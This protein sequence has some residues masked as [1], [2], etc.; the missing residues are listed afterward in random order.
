MVGVT[1]SSSG[2]GPSQDTVQKAA[3]PTVQEVSNDPV[4]FEVA[5]VGIGNIGEERE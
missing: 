4:G 1:R 3:A 2:L 5:P